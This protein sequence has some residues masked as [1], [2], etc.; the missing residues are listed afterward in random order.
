[1]STVRPAVVAGLFY[2]ARADELE[3]TIDRLLAAASAPAMAGA[4]RALVAPHAGYAFSGAVAASAFATLGR[5][6]PV[7]RVALIGPSHFTPLRGVAVSGAESW[8]TPLG[9]VPV[10]TELR[11]AAVTAGA[12]VD[13]HPHARDH[14][15]EVELP[16]LQRV[17]GA[18]LRVLPVAVG[19]ALEEA[20]A[21][22]GALA[23]DAL[24]VV[25]TDLSHYHD[26]ATARRLDRR[27]ADAVVTLDASAIGPFDACGAGALRALLVHAR[28]AGW[29]C[30]ELDLRTSAEA[31]GEVDRVVGYGAFA[32]AEAQ[33]TRG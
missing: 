9:T 31:S 21:V 1:V 10:D 23:R 32:L 20:A 13:D 2:P 4:P 28:R 5:E 6:P 18:G 26:D 30:T 11:L 24:V 7:S 29:S 14:A 19:D 27:T 16:F 3:T 17:L 22:V 25:S 12:V 8:Q 15:L 33:S